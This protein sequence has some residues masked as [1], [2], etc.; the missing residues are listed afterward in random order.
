MIPSITFYHHEQI[1]KV[2]ST[3]SWENAPKLKNSTLIPTSWF[4]Q[5][6]QQTEMMSYIV[7]YYHANSET[8]K[9]HFLG[10]KQQK[11]LSL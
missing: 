2:L 9:E 5:M 8:F 7:L 3:S 11:T 4:F 1:K 6:W 10:K